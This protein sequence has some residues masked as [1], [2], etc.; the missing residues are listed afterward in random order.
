MKTNGGTLL[1]ASRSANKRLTTGSFCFEE[2][3]FNAGSHHTNLH[4]VMKNG[5]ALKAGKEKQK[6]WRIFIKNTYKP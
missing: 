2:S 4:F 6:S 3:V 1:R 5:R